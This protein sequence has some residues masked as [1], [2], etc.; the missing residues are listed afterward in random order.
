[1]PR[2]PDL[3]DKTEE[4]P[5]SRFGGVGLDRIEDGRLKGFDAPGPLRL[6]SR[7]M[8]GQHGPHY[9]TPPFDAEGQVVGT[10]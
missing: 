7:G 1:M 10:I 3:P 4:I 6:D 9:P 8:S 5:I 2:R